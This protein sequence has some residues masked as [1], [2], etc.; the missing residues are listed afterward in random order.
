[1][2]LPNKVNCPTTKI[3]GKYVALDIHW[4]SCGN[5]ADPTQLEF[6]PL[7]GLQS[8]GLERSQSTEDVTDDRT[9]GDYAELIGTIKS[10]TLSGSGIMNHT[11]SSTSNLAMLDKLYSQE[12][13]TYLHVRITEPH[14]TTYAYCIV[15]N[16]SKDWP[17]T[18][19]I[20]FEIELVNTAS[21]YGV[22]V[23][24][25][26]PVTVTGIELG[27]TAITLGV[28]ASMTLSPSVT[29]IAGSRSFNWTSATPAAATVSASGV[30]TGVDAG[31]SVITVAHKDFPLVTD[32]VTVTVS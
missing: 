17:A 26:N 3:T 4:E 12:G 5:V 7:G 6:H 20:T 23:T 18:A 19:P 10:F 13:T 16:F 29:P 8:K 24:E 27:A 1:M 2:A 22:K 25:T 15:T 28:G 30:V 14:I 9:V 31:S 32:T 21:A 11:D